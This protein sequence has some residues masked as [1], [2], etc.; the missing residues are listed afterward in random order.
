M[1][2]FF[3]SGCLTV[4]TLTVILVGLRHEPVTATFPVTTSKRV[5]SDRTDAGKPARTI[6]TRLRNYVPKS[7]AITPP[8]NRAPVALC[9]V[10][11]QAIEGLSDWHAFNE[12]IDKI[13]VHPYP[14]ISFEFNKEAVKFE[15]KYTTWIGKIPS[16]PG[17][18]LVTVASGNTYDAI[19][20]LPGTSQLSY[21]VEADGRLITHEADPA[22][23]GCAA[24]G[25]QPYRSVVHLPIATPL[26]TTYI[27][28]DPLVSLSAALDA[29]AKKVDVLVLYDTDALTAA[30]G[31]SADGA[32]YIDSQSKAMIESGN[33]VINQ[34]GVTNFFWRYVGSVRAPDYTK[35]VSLSDDLTAMSSGAISAFVG[36]QRTSHGA[37][38]VFLWRGNSSPDVSGSAFMGPITNPAT[39]VAVGLWGSSYKVI[40]HELGH[41]FGCKHD[42]AHAGINNIPVPEGDGHF[43]YGQLWTNGNGAT[44]STIMGYGTSIIP[45][46]STPNI[47][48]HITSALADRVGNNDWGTLPL[49]FD[50]NDSKAAYNTKVLQDN[51]AALSRLVE[52]IAVPAITSQ[53]A[54]VSVQTGLSFS[55][56]ATASGG[57]LSYQW[58]KDGAVIAS[59]TSSTYS[60]SSAGSSDA[61]SYS[62]VVTNPLGSATSNSATVTVIAAQPPPSGG[63]GS[64]GSGGGGGGGGAVSPLFLAVIS[65]LACARQFAKKFEDDSHKGNAR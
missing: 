38:Q 20:I 35:T 39:A 36:T 33:V 12:R 48:V 1:K 57:N 46:F 9:N 19:L 6:S 24:P 14:D 44:A 17:A 63:G 43:N 54:N 40:I 13:T 2:K 25:V 56:G 4:I 32:G 49:G 16:I 42:R 23:E 7:A 59:A 60:K 34:S 62:V 8:A 31:V 65:L 53:P 27:G 26:A 22:E 5:P 58:S 11:P 10:F 29:D 21:H 47:T 52:E 28:A 64:G 37:D 45:Y 18:S 61:G 3:A 15:G 55:V 41:G 50:V 51:S 30:S